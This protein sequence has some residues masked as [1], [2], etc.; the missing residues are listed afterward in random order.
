M[1]ALR[2]RSLQFCNRLSINEKLTATT[3]KLPNS[4]T[5]RSKTLPIHRNWPITADIVSWVL[6]L[7][8]IIFSNQILILTNFSC[9]LIMM[10]SAQA[11]EKQITATFSWT[12]VLHDRTLILSSSQKN[13]R[14]PENSQI[15][16]NRK[17]FFICLHLSSMPI[18]GSWQWTWSHSLACIFSSQ[19][20][21]H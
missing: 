19:A 2:H 18:W 4:Y 3:F 11:V 9:L 15:A 5:E 6:Q 21:H 12:I 7:L 8:T 17:C 1:S 10:I 13:N 16:Y 14:D 20:L